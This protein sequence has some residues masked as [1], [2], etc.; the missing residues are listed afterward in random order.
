MFALDQDCCARGG[1]PA[2]PS[3]VP[4]GAITAFGVRADSAP[5]GAI[6]LGAVRAAGP[7][8]LDG[9]AQRFDGNNRLARL[10]VPISGAANI[11]CD[12]RSQRVDS[13]QAALVVGQQSI[14]CHG[15]MDSA[16]MVLEL[17]RAVIQ[18][19]CFVKYREA[20]RLASMIYTID[21]SEI[22]GGIGDAL[23]SASRLLTFHFEKDATNASLIGE[24]LIDGLVAE[25]RDA[26]VAG[27]FP[28]SGSV[29]RAL[30]M[31]ESASRPVDAHELVRAAG[32]T[33]PNLRRNVREC[34]GSTLVTLLQDAE[35]ERA[36]SWLSSDRE[37]RSIEQIAKVCGFSRTESFARA[38]RRR[39]EETPTQTRMRLFAPS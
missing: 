35:L 36:R 9:R 12:G 27:L 6:Q 30:A 3:A 15:D 10:I 14:A 32:I 31:L 29:T 8:F 4:M 38:Y 2:C 25:L 37:A 11:I 13:G 23:E 28:A 7:Y 17:S 26:T 18:E 1:A 19:R 5:V 16:T 20:R 33:L 34:T 21:R 24:A 22:C 39:Y